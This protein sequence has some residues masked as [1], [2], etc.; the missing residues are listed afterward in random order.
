VFY[1]GG[2]AWGCPQPPEA[3]N[4]KSDF[5]RESNQSDGLPSRASFCESFCPLLKMLFVPRVNK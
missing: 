2:R 4:D 5:L 3:K 1:V